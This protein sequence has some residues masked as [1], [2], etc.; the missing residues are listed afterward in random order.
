MRMAQQL[1]EG[2]DIDGETVGLI[3]YM[4]TDGVQMAREAVSAIRDHV[5]RRVRRRTTCRAR[6]ANT[7][8]QASR[9]RRKRMRR[10]ARPTSPARRT[11]SAR[12]LSHD[13]R[14]L[15]ELIWK[16]AVASQMQSAELDQVS[17]DVTD[18]KG[19][20]LAR[21]RLDRRV[22]RLP[23]AVSRGHTT[24]PRRGRRQPH[25]AAD[26]ASATRCG[27]GKVD[28]DAALHPAAAALLGSQPG[29]EAGGAGHRPAV[30]LC[31]DPV[32][33]AGP[34][35]RPAGEAALHPGGPRPAG[36]RVPG[37]LLRA[38]RRYRLHRRAGGETRRHLRPA[39][40]TG[41]R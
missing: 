31:V 30:H 2:I 14:R 23:E 7:P 3:T 22:R 26:G 19:L 39:S 16:R 33:A 21:H 25:A 24:T 5:K 38:L 15:Y 32:G 1:Y 12:D 18:G 41:G 9:T 34:Q 10:S 4:R 20:T 40:R 8:D 27:R 11:R 6:R 36:H 28:A 35:I 29:Q 17:V 13:Q 37:Q